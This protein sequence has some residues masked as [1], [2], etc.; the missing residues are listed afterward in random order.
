ME[1][2]SIDYIDEIDESGHYCIHLKIDVIPSKIRLFGIY[3]QL[4]L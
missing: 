4:M 1:I 3:I 2:S